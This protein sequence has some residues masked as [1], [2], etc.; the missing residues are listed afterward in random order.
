MVFERFRGKFAFRTQIFEIEDV[1]QN[2]RAVGVLHLISRAF[3]YVE[4]KFG[5]VKKD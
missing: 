1:R 4:R 2:V 3:D 5:V